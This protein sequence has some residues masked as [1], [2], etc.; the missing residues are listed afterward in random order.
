[1][2]AGIIGEESITISRFLS[3]LNLD[4]RDRVELL[5]YQ[6]LNDLVQICIKVEQQNLRKSFSKRNQ[7]QTNSYVKK[8]FKKEE[9]KEEPPRNLGKGKEGSASSHTR[10][11][12][13]KCFKCLG[14]GH[15]ASQCPTKKTMILRGVDR[16]S[17]QDEN[18]SES[19][20]E[21]SNESNIE[22]AHPCDGDLLMVRRILNNQPSPQALTQRENIFHTRCKILENTCSL[23]VDSGS[24]CN[25][26]STRLV[27]KLSLT[28]LPHPKPY[29][30][31]WLNEDGDLAVNHQVKVKF[32][33]GKYEDSVLCDVVPMEACHILLGRPWQ[34]DKKTMHNGLTNKITFTHKA[35]KFVLHP[36]LPSQ[37]AEDQLQMKN[38]T[39]KEKD[40]DKKKS[41]K[42][43]K[44]K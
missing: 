26:C 18:E 39:E 28:V 14:R 21:E 11:S 36:L 17:S 38:K 3:G 40:E 10:T 16:Y 13:I 30:L 2:R 33:I 23:I 1:M 22:D 7:A 20:S 34:F 4:I 5:P 9:K 6:D 35:K 8:D 32:S 43:P 44:A 42:S 37:V 24:C 15:I 27:D 19:G 41:S 12:E 29:K 31:H 25:C